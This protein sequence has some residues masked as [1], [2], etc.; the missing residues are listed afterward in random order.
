[1]N[2]SGVNGGGEQGKQG[3]VCV[4]DKLGTCPMLVTIFIGATLG[5]SCIPT[6][7]YMVSFLRSEE[8]AKNSAYS[9]RPKETMN[10]RKRIPFDVSS[11]IVRR[12]AGK[13]ACQEMLDEKRNQLLA[14][15]ILRNA[16]GRVVCSPSDTVPNEQSWENHFT[17]I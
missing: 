1:M 13:M 10:E 15:L 12:G 14:G 16:L 6:T 2:V 4:A 7:C 3:V 8:W 5:V 9:A 17:A 11:P